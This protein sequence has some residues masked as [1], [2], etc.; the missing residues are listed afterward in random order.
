[1]A[2]G[3]DDKSS[4]GGSGTSST[5]AAEALTKAVTFENGML[6]TGPMP[7]PT[8]TSIS[9]L[10][11]DGDPVAPGG[12][13]LMSFDVDA[14]GVSLA[15][16][17][18]SGADDHF[19]VTPMLLSLGGGD[20]GA[21]GDDAGTSGGK[22]TH[23]ELKLKLAKN[24]CDK[25]CDKTYDIEVKEAVKLENGKVSSQAKGSFKLDCSKDGDHSLCGK[26]TTSSSSVGSKV[27]KAYTNLT[28][29]LCACTGDTTTGTCKGIDV[30]CTSKVFDKYSK[31]IA[32]QLTCMQT[33]ID[34]QQKCVDAAKCD[35]KKLSMCPIAMTGMGTDPIAV[36]CGKLPDVVD[37]EI[38]VCNPG[39]GGNDN[40]DPADPT[41]GNMGSTS[42]V[43]CPTGSDAGKQLTLDKLCDGN[44]DCTDGTDEMVC[45]P[46]DGDKN[47]FTIY[48]RCDAKMDCADGTD[49]MG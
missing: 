22:G 2:C 48:A 9:L 37:S 23:V 43:V 27:V 40:C 15:L 20:A 31:D 21:A 17:Q 25:L 32:D 11:V 24:A 10:P 33:F 19:E 5:M 49:E 3:S 36:A 39:Q 14:D 47:K 38:N 45:I 42:I 44:N 13:A 7:M 28:S 6:I 8:D 30:T 41:C 18:F 4:G 34:D 12:T 29:T 16:V 46:C 35:P 26:T 1:M